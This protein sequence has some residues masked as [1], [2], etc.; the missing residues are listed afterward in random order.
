MVVI[1][2]DKDANITTSITAGISNVT[3]DSGGNYTITFNALPDATYDSEIVEFTAGDGTSST[4]PLNI[5]TID[6]VPPTL[7]ETTPIQPLSN[8]TRPSVEIKSTKAGTITTSIATGIS[9]P[10]NRRGNVGKNIITFNELVPGTY[11]G[12][13]V[14]FTDD[15]GNYKDITLSPFTINT[16]PPPTPPPGTPPTLNIITHIPTLSNN[17]TPMVVISSDKELQ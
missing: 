17:R 3:K 9:N 12:K 13:T 11:S 2:S 10:P 7:E 5:F 16:T 8:N 15:A 1:S 6:T 4:I 14:K